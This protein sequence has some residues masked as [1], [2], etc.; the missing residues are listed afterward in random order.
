MAV[1]YQIDTRRRVVWVRC[2]G[3]LTSEDLFAFQRDVWSRP[4]LEGFSELVDASGAEFEIPPD[5]G[6]DLRSLAEFSAGTDSTEDSQLAIVAADDLAFGLGRMYATYRELQ[7]RGTRRVEVFRS[8][9]DALAWLGL[10]G[11]DG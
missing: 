8:R 7:S 11:R 10:D 6:L 9:A 5:V 3:R 1:D 2:S 4:E